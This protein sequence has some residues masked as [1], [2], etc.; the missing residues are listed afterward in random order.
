MPVSSISSSSSLPHDN[1]ISNSLS[2]PCIPS[3]PKEVNNPTTNNGK[4]LNK[5]INDNTK[6][7]KKAKNKGGNYRGRKRPNFPPNVIKILKNWLYS[8][9]YPF[10]TN[11]EKSILCKQTGL[12]IVR[13]YLY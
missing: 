6:L 11:T 2:S 9:S 5:I 1:C 7:I 13:I 10:P 3:N 8:N 4:F 12:N